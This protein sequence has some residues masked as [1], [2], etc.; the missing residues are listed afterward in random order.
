[1]VKYEGE[2]SIKEE[3]MKIAVSDPSYQASIDQIKRQMANTNIVAEDLVE[4]IRM[5][6]MI[7]ED[8]RKYAE[9]RQAAIA[10]GLID[11]GMFPPEFDKTIIISL[12]IVLYGLQ[13]SLVQEGYARGG[14]RVAGKQLGRMGQGG[15]TMLAHINPREAEVLRRMGGQGTVNP[16]TGLQEYK[17]LKNIIKTAL[18]IALSIVAPGLGTA[19]GTAIGLSGTAAAVA[20]GALLGGATSFATGGDPLLGALTGGIGGAA[21]GVSEFLGGFANIGEPT[22]NLLAGAGTGALTSAIRGGNIAQG[23]MLGA[24]G[25]M[26]KPQIENASKSVV[27]SLKSTFSPM[28]NA[29]SDFTSPITQGFS[30]DT[31]PYSGISDAVFSEQGSSLGDT[32]VDTN[33]YDFM[34][35]N[36]SM[37]SY[38]DNELMGGSNFESARVPMVLKKPLD[39]IS[40]LDTVE[41]R[42]QSYDSP[43]NP[44][45][46]NASNNVNYPNPND[47]QNASL[48]NDMDAVNVPNPSMA[49][50]SDS[51]LMGGENVG[52]S[53]GIL[54][55]LS[56][57]ISSDT[58]KIGGIVALLASMDGGSGGGVGMP[59]FTPEQEEYFNRNLTTWDWNKIQ[60]MAN[61]KGTSVT[62]F[63]TNPKFRSEAASG[64]FDQQPSLVQS[65]ASQRYARGGLSAIPGYATGSGDGRA[66]LINAR[67]SDGEYVIDAESV[68]MLG[69][70]SNKAGAKM[71]ND[72]RKNL[73]SH[74]G[75]ALADG[76]FSPDAKSPLEYMKRSA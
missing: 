57:V 19:I 23:A 49:S 36:P 70:G 38:S 30:T 67:L 52:D 55:R 6:E 1:M 28:T 64:M 72:M 73:R 8:P 22:A 61:S 27:N 37:A 68:S 17:G 15:D 14:L 62:E 31:T 43:Q 9:I 7:I 65:V 66:D 35:P 26:F 11:E 59:Q 12:L 69:N 32:F 76:R 39:P 45:L 5:L 74:K 50:Y 40:N 54:S 53:Q 63:I 46:G 60:A 42:T 71:L 47:V 58:A 44:A 10:D 13:D 41:A 34:A 20:G 51:E 33:T 4:A 25:S 56:N 16:N 24:A 48:V 21:S 18:P 29:V 2:M 3:I 75:K